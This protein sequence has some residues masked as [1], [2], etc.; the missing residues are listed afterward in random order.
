MV[1]AEVICTSEKAGVWLPY[2]LSFYKFVAKIVKLLDI[3]SAA[4]IWVKQFDRDLTDSD[5]Y[6]IE[7]EI[8]QQITSTLAD[9]IGV[10]TRV[11]VKRTH[12]KPCSGLTAF[13]ASLKCGVK[14]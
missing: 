7:D 6:E 3:E 9:R 2:L 13:E 14:P 5:K 11:L 8:T 1:F 12:N 4:N 10:T